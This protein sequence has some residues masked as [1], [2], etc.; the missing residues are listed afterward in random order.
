MTAAAADVAYELRNWIYHI[1]AGRY[2]L[3]AFLAQRTE[4]VIIYAHDAVDHLAYSDLDRMRRDRQIV[5]PA[6]YRIDPLDTG[7]PDI[8]LMTWFL[9]YDEFKAY[10][11]GDVEDPSIPWDRAGLVMEMG[12]RTR[13]GEV[14]VRQLRGLQ[15]QWDRWAQDYRREMVYQPADYISATYPRQSG[16]ANLD[17]DNYMQHLQQLELEAKSIAR[18][19]RDT[20]EKAI[21][22]KLATDL[23]TGVQ[24][25][26]I[27]EEEANQVSEPKGEHDNAPQ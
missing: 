8:R 18:T 26:D 3:R 19:L 14:V 27:S 4:E 7:G 9:T 24:C 5:P 16:K 23:R 13:I 22:D 11:Q 2:G 15:V 25:L 17:P 6:M 21:A 10:D 12:T 1:G 20:Q